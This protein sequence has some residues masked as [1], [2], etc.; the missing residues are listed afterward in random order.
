MTR[1][2]EANFKESFQRL[3]R[4]DERRAPSFARSWAG[5]KSRLEPRRRTRWARRLAVAGLLSLSLGA[6]WLVLRDGATG[7]ADPAETIVSQTPP[8]AAS[9]GPER[10]P[11]PPDKPPGSGYD[12][13]APK[14][15][16]AARR[17]RPSPAAQPPQS[18]LAILSRWR[19]PTEFLLRTPGDAFL[20][21]VPRLGDPLGELRIGG[22]TITPERSNDPEE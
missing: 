22:G 6:A 7:K 15:G 2:E 8:A 11:S 14:L 16:R 20:K 10:P 9:N 21:T 1:E 3:K 17:P 19:S 5:A 18:D 4:E 12:R 13:V